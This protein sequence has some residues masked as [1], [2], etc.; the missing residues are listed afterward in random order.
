[1][2][3]NA[4]PSQV[5]HLLQAAP[6]YN[7][8]LSGLSDQVNPSPYKRAE[9]GRVANEPFVGGLGARFVRDAG[10][11]NLER[12][13][14]GMMTPNLRGL[15]NAA[16]MHPSDVDLG[17]P[18]DYKNAPLTRDEQLRWQRA[19][20]PALNDEL[21]KV[22]DS[23]DWEDP[24]SRA[25]AVKDAISKAKDRAA[26]DSLGLTAADIRDRTEAAQRRERQAVAR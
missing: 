8:I 14:A 22:R 2:L 24:M 26:L 15:L 11:A 1:M 7:D 5:E 9:Q 23:R 6:A 19:L 18:S 16:R 17:V 25:A 4:H 13:Q 12:A 20:R 21:A 3:Q 10:G